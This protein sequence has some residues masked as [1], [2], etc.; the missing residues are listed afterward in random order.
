MILSGGEF[1]MEYI[2]R[3]SVDD[4]PQCNY[5]RQKNQFVADKDELT[6]C[7]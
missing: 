1:Y 2:V 4:F 7:Q 6:I 3:V 5:R